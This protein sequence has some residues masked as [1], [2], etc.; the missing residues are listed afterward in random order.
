VSSRA[1]IVSLLGPAFVA[2]VAYLDPGNVAANIT[3]GAQLGFLLV[4]VVVAGNLIAWLVQYLSASLGI[5]TGKSLPEVLGTRITSRG[6]RLGYWAQGE[7]I[8]M[9]TDVAEVIG[10]AIAL[11]LLWGIPLWLGGLI[12]GVVSL[13]F[14]GVHGRW[15]AKPFERLIVF[16]L[17]IIAVGF[18]AILWGQ[19]IDATAFASG[20]VPR[21]EG[22]ESLL[23]AAA[24]LGAT[25]MPHAIY[26]H[27]GFSR[28]RISQSSTVPIRRLR[29]AT[30]VDV[31][32]ALLLAGAVNIALLVIGAVVL[33]GEPGTDTLDGAFVAIAAASGTLMATFFAVALLAS[34]LASTAVGAYAGAEIMHGLIRRRI[35]PMVRRGITVVPAIIILIIGV[36]PTTA[37]IYSQ[38]IL[39]W[40]IPFALIPLIIVTGDTKI[41]GEYRSHGVVR[42]LAGV[43]TALVIIINS[44]LVALILGV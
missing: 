28:D 34:S 19:P 20:L 33:Y 9:A 7:L 11:N 30:R 29:V 32:L 39:S 15:G 6:W 12:V 17:L 38:V 3:A 36:E 2:G 5:V 24:I 42:G 1:A 41:M 16:F 35:R 23:L 22:S 31:T 26:A 10:G 18:G 14:L 40:G 21:L 44:G 43:A 25:V 13:A 37:L 4:W 27:S 8:A